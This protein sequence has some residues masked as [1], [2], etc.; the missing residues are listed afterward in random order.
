[1]NAYRGSRAM[2][3][4]VDVVKLDVDGEGKASGP[5]LRGRVAAEIAKPLRRGVLL[6]T[7]KNKPSEWFDI[8]FEK[9]PCYCFSCGL[10]GHSD[11]ECSS[12]SPHNAMGKLP[13]DV[14]LRAPEERRKRLQSFAQATLLNPL[15][16]A[17]LQTFD[18]QGGQDG[19]CR[20]SEPSKSGDRTR[21]K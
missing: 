2:S 13:Y 19:E 8:Q 20:A 16:V 15:E 9:L 7:D 17:H 6:K 11:L 12:P 18:S 4:V 1:M 3:L 5:F 21:G 10:I 14:R